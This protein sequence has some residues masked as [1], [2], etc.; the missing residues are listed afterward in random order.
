[1]TILNFYDL[2]DPDGSPLL[3]VHGIKSHGLRFRR[4]ATEAWPQRRTI[5]VDLRGH[6]RSTP[7][8]PWSIDRHID[9]LIE[10][11][12]SLGLDQI[13]VV[14]HS[15]GGAISLALLA[16]APQR[17]R[18][19]VMLDPALDQT[20]QWATARAEDSL[21]NNSWES[22]DVATAVHS[23]GLSD[24]AHS[25]VVEDIGQ[26]LV[27]GADGRY[28]FRYHLPAVITGWGEMSK[29][30]PSMIEVRPALLVVADRA[31]LVT[32]RTESTL[33]QL[34]AG[35]LTTEHIDCGHMVYWEAFEELADAMIRFWSAH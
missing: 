7:D 13:D 32:A 30:L 35:Q 17:V 24:V 31:Q 34:F 12:D 21:S 3:A 4:L 20:G 9:D 1:M 6:G 33:M 10:T 8:G 25:G 15:Y 27:H 28:R 16:R 5:A 18:S 23:E 22:I 14:G 19:L 29:P 2:G 11:L 26:H